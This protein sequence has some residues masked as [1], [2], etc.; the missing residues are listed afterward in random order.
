MKLLTVI[1][2]AGATAVMAQESD[3]FPPDYCIPDPGP[4]CV[5]GFKCQPLNPGTPEGMGV[6]SDY[7]ES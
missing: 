5:I 3:K 4:G 6:V 1:F 7:N 2:L